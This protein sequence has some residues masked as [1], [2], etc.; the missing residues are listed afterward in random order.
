MVDKMAYNYNNNKNN[1]ELTEEDLDFAFG[2][3]NMSYD[4]AKDY[5]IKHGVANV[6]HGVSQ[7]NNFGELSE[8]ELDNY[9]GG[10]L[11]E[12]TSGKGRR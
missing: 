3:T 5:A 10:I 2:G 11:I 9:L 6:R 1:G 4:E 7:D 8:K 12:H